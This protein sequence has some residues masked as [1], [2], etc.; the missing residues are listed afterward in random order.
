MP[1]RPGTFE[2]GPYDPRTLL[3]LLVAA[4]VIWFLFTSVLPS[5]TG[6]TIVV[7]VAGTLGVLALA[8]ILITVLRARYAERWG[9]TR[10]RRAVVAR[11][12]TDE[13]EYGLPMGDQTTQ[14]LADA[15]DQ[16]AVPTLYTHWNFWVSF[17]VGQVKEEEFRV[18]E[19]V[20]LEL[21]EGTEGVLTSRGE[22]LVRFLPLSTEPRPKASEK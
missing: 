4:L 1:Y 11:K 10:S 15:L 17:D 16:D 13:H 22:R 12:W 2:S 8:H 7:V 20:Y 18:P 14:L 19:E 6:F 5:P 9:R 21:E 3:S